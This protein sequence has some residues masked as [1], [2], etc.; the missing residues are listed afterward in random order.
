M[1]IPL[2]SNRRSFISTTARAGLFVPLATPMVGSLGGC[3]R[4]TSPDDA[5]GESAGASAGEGAAATPSPITGETP[6][7]VP[8]ELPTDWD[9]VKFNLE[10]GQRGAIPEA[11]MGDIKGP[12]GVPK[13]LGKHLPYVP[14]GIPDDR[15]PSG[16]LPIMWGN[17]ELGYAKHPNAPRS[18]ENPEGP[19]YDWIRVAKAGEPATELETRFDEWPKPTEAVQGRIIG[20]DGKDPTEDS[21]KNTAYLALLPEGCKPGDVLRVWAH[22]LTHG[23]YVDFVTLS[24]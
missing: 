16:Y 10:R 17:P 7:G 2:L 13:H 21:G 8:A 14:N 9:A 15:L 20:A 12:D 19:W 11:Y 23:E 24:A 5:L 18:E 3:K 4:E 1:N 22:C 6:S